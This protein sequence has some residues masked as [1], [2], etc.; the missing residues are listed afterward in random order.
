ML[1]P[2]YNW[3]SAYPDQ[4]GPPEKQSIQLAVA[5]DGGLPASPDAKLPAFRD[6]DLKLKAGVN[7]VDRDLSSSCRVPQAN[8]GNEA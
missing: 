3:T 1:E 4:I 2:L 5:I 6:S 8:K 7:G